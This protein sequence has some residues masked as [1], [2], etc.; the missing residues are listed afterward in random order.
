MDLR[1]EQMPNERAPTATPLKHDAFWHLQAIGLLK[2]TDPMKSMTPT[3]TRAE[4]D[5][6]KALEGAEEA[7]VAI[8]DNGVSMHPYLK[9]AA[10]ESTSEVNNKLGASQGEPDAGSWHISIDLSASPLLSA[11]K[12]TA[13]GAQRDPF[14]NDFLESLG[15]Y[16]PNTEI[17]YQIALHKMVQENKGGIP[18]DKGA[19]AASNGLFS[20]HGTAC[21]GIIAASSDHDP[22]KTE[23]R[24]YYRGV[25][26]QSRLMSITTSFSPRPDLLLQAFLL[27]ATEAA[28]ADVILIPRGLPR[29]I[30][31]TEQDFRDQGIADEAPKWEA[32]RETIIKVSRHIPVVCAAGNES[33]DKPIAPARFAAS[34]NGIIGVAAMN[35]HGN[36]SS[37]SNF[38]AG[39]TVAAPSDDAE[40]FNKYQ[41]RLDK[42]D[43]F[44]SDYPYEYFI[45]NSNP[46]IETVPFGEASILAIDIPGAYGFSDA[47]TDATANF[48]T[49]PESYF[50]DFG[51]TSAASSIVAG[52]AALMQRA[53]KLKKSGARLDGI[54]LKKVLQDSARKGNFP[55]LRLAG[56]NAV[57]TGVDKVDSDEPLSFEECFGA[58]L[59]AADR[60]VNLILYGNPEGPTS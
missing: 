26:P 6:W 60:A 45:Q 50:T 21:A 5:T 20:A 1:R 35:Y 46:K 18:F 31:Y 51:G 38:G 13:R 22:N 19:P 55:H 49:E 27:A 42:T 30:L 44:Y 16:S 8:I 33:E 47:A 4:T 11:D 17:P 29:E 32:L 58:G 24:L 52:V 36:R 14:S 7:L 28:N 10:Q 3:E 43:R 40:I 37:Y 54:E 23:N 53:A 25:D 2:P 34:D 48:S 15:L 57:A 56:D 41:A 39:I 59:V 9:G 12:A